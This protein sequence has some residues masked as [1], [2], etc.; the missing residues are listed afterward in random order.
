M[1]NV[2]RNVPVLNNGEI[3]QTNYFIRVQISYLVIGAQTH[4]RSRVC[5]CVCNFHLH[6]T[7]RS[8]VQ[9]TAE[10]DILENG[11]LEIGVLGNEILGI[12]CSRHR[13]LVLVA[14]RWSYLGLLSKET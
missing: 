5:V 6:E 10:I 3:K 8:R 2:V 4:A 11:V 7:S 14:H 1:T 12:V 9:F 13:H